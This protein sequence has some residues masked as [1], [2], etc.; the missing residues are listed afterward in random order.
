M[1]KTIEQSNRIRIL[2]ADDHPAVREGLAA[3]L[4]PQLGFEV[5]AQAGD[6][7]EAVDL[8]REYRPDIT[9]MDLRMPR[10]DGLTAIRAILTDY[11]EARIIVVTTFDGE[12]EN[13]F[14]AGAKAI[15]L[16]ETDWEEILSVIRAIHSDSPPQSR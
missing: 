14:R 5:V 15:V 11:P 13:S 16:K 2:I 10:M 4:I 1:Q 7:Q 9:L 12:E 8:F 6:G 3:L